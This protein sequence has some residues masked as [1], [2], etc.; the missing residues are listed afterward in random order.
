MPSERRAAADA[1]E[2]PSGST[3][4]Y[5]LRPLCHS[6]HFVIA[7]RLAGT[8]PM[9]DVADSAPGHYSTVRDAMCERVFPGCRV[10]HIDN[11]PN[12][13]ND[14]AFRS[15]AY[16]QVRLMALC[17][18]AAAAVAVDRGPVIRAMMARQQERVNAATSAY[19]ALAG[20]AESRTYVALERTTPS[21]Q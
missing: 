1:R 12:G 3:E 6:G 17:T 16:A 13:L 5:W 18:C 19:E 2:V 14:C 7:V 10:A 21:V 9:V 11:S 8:P 15:A 20:W 4:P